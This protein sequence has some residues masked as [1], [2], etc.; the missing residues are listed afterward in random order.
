MS[1]EQSHERI[2]KELRMVLVLFVGLS[3]AMGVLYFLDQQYHIIDGAASQ[4][5]RSVVQ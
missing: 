3:A 4:V 1:A 2:R 5:Y